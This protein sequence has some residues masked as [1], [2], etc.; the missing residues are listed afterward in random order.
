M[1][2]KFNKILAIV[3]CLVMAIG[4]VAAV[5]E[6]GPTPS[7]VPT[8]APVTTEAPV[9]T[10]VP[11]VPPVAES[12]APSEAPAAD[13]PTCTCPD[14]EG[15]DKA[16]EDYVHAKDCPLYVPVCTCEGTEEEKA[17]EGF[18]HAEGCDFYVAPVDPNAELYEKLMATTTAEEFLALVEGMSEEDEQAFSDSLSA[19][20]LEALR[21]HIQ[22]IAPAEEATPPQT[23]TFTDA[24][25]FMPPVAVQTVRRLLRSAPKPLAE[26]Q[27]N[28]LVTTKTATVNPDGTYTISIESY[29]T[30]TVTTSTKTTPVDIVLVL[31]QSGSMCFNFAGDK[32]GSNERQTA[33]KQAVNNFISAVN[34][35]YSND[36][37]HR[38]ALVTFG[39]GASTLLGWT[40]V[41]DAGKEALQGAI[42]G[43][44]AGPAGATNVAAGMGEAVALMGDRYN[45]TG[46]NKPRQKVVIVFT[47]GVP[48]TNTVFDIGVADA[49]INTAKSMKDEGVTIYSIGI[50]N[51]ADPGQLYGAKADYATFSDIECN[52]GTT[53]P[54]FIWGATG[55]AA[56]FGDVPDTDVPAGN[57]FLN[58]LSSNFNSA[59][60]VGLEKG[61]FGPKIVMGE[62]YNGWHVGRA[63][64]DGYKII[65]NFSRNATGYYLTA[66]NANSLNTI[67]QTISENINTPEIELGSETVVKDIVSP[68]FTIPS[69]T[70]DV[71][72]YVADATSASGATW[73]TR[74]E[75]DLTPDVNGSTIIVSGFDFN[76]NFV[77]DK[78][79]EDGSFGKKLIIEFNV[80]RK[81]GFLGGNAVPTNGTESGVYDKDGTLVEAFDIP[82]VDLPIHYAFSTTDQTI[83]LGEKA[84]LTRISSSDIVPD[85]SNN[86]FVDIRY[87]VTDPED[88]P[89]G[90]MTIP[91]G[92]TSGEWTWTPD[93]APALEKD[94][95][96][97]INCVVSP[98]I[99]KVDGVANWEET[100]SATVYV[101]TCTLTI[102]KQGSQDDNQGFIFKVTG[103]KAF[104]VSVQGNGSVT[105][106]GLPIGSYTVTE[107]GWSWRYSADGEKTADLTPTAH[108]VSITVNNDLQNPY[109]LDGSAYAQNK[110]AK[111]AAKG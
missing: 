54:G 56:T 64:I 106:A 110:A 34:E 77:S 14:V 65:S 5:V 45:Y 102:T 16:A 20:Q 81:E 78:A 39:S 13:T 38:M 101:K 92:Q 6:G 23:V 44:P 18:V 99:P 90:T 49:A 36:A 28:G 58:Y 109:L 103:P 111:P 3:L 53:A 59:T 82:T 2:N 26:E 107:D 88:K 4:S 108:D 100:K 86:A 69:N 95:E 66:A 87:T 67:F 63:K 71:K 35:K 15:V 47:D 11:S 8:E 75:T 105:I 55:W 33:M 96:Y 73:A 12:P 10:A 9:E 31:D 91:A 84:D 41:D 83:Y 22:E 46:A 97:T 72:V 93:A 104:T 40:A 42:N 24:G 85:G 76:E 52:G 68:H 21:A 1:N 62:T 80:T 7:P 61:S 29:T 30:G 17:A 25:P 89:V 57:R 51:G 43:L 48:T 79:K 60:Q 50:F 19:E 74:E 98:S 27:D 94:T 37:D 32:N 70:S